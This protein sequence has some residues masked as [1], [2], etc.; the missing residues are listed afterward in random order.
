MKNRK[1]FTLLVVLVVVFA[2]M[3]VYA[4][5]KKEVRA[6]VKL[7]KGKVMVKA[8]KKWQALKIGTILTKDKL[9]KVGKGGV[10]KMKTSNGKLLVVK[11]TKKGVKTVKMATLFANAAKKKS[12]NSLMNKIGKGKAKNEFGATAVAGVRGADVSKQ[13]KKVKKED[14]NWE[15]K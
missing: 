7:V 12:M 15:K 13:K 10:V 11:N 6:K 5:K 1:F 4:A 14:L 3:S 2:S 9:I 8:G